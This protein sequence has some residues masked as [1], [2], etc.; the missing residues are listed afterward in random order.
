[1]YDFPGI[2]E[3]DQGIVRFGSV[4]T[5]HGDS[6]VP[7]Y[8]EDRHKWPVLVPISTARVVWRE[9]NHNRVVPVEKGLLEGEV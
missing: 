8:H 5:F 3:T 1:M 9:S 4:V 2:I 7:L 6:F